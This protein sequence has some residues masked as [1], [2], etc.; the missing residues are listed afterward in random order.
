[1]TT[2]TDAPAIVGIYESEIGDLGGLTAVELQALA[3]RGALA[4]AGMTL[5]DT[6]AL[7][8]LAPYSQPHAMFALSLAEY[9]GLRCS[10][11]ETVDVGGTA[12]PMMMI[13]HA[14]DGIRSGLHGTAVCVFGEAARTGRPH[15]GHGWTL[16]SEFGTEEWEQPAGLVGLVSPYALLAQR[17]LHEYGTS[18]E[19]FCA[20]SLA[21]REH[22]RRKPNAVMRDKPL[23]RDDYF[24][25]RMISDPISLYDCSVI[26]DGAGALVITSA[27]RARDVA[28]RPVTV[29]GTGSAQTHKHLSQLTPLDQLG[30]GEA[31]RRSFG[32]AGIGIADV[33]VL[34]AHDAFT[35]STMLTIEG[36]GLC[37][38]G[39]GEAYARAGQLALGSPCPVNTHGGLLS[40]GHTGGILNYTEAVTQL[41]GDAA[42]RQVPNAEIA[43][44]A[45]TGGLFG[46][47]GVMTLGRG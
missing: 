8:A 9:L 15:S 26:V 5:P 29:L 27:D 10:I 16:G 33:D 37:G 2:A 34:Y 11:A 23:T 17:Y 39:E 12:T 21:M 36:V 24:G 6:D 47:C 4:D 44:V 20:V 1:M 35:V 40:Q 32:Q 13:K 45:G 38:P 28:H 14:I 31:A 19:G 46:M 22:A 7:Y 18:R 30:M 43:V 25:A 41:R 42:D 3:V